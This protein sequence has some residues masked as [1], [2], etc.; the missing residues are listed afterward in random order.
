MSPPTA[1]SLGKMKMAILVCDPL[2]LL[3]MEAS[4]T[5]C[6]VKM[7]KCMTRTNF[8]IGWKTWKRA[9]FFADNIV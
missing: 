8:A 5:F 6:F 2:I 1:I 7:V 3:K 9:C 4:I